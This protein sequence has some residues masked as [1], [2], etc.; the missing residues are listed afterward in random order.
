[1]SLSVVGTSG[2]ER[3]MMGHTADRDEGKIYMFR[4]DDRGVVVWG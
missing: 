3:E 1:M 4:S 2:K